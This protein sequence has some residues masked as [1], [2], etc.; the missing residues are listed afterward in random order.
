MAFELIIKPIVIFDI[1]EAVEYYEKKVAGLGNRFYNQFLASLTDIQNKPFTYS[2]IK[3]PVRRCKI[4]HFPYK[5]FYTV[6]EKTVFII[7][8]AHTK[9]SNS[10]VR[11]RLRLL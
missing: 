7:G 11:R 2:Y 5:V 3:D 6:D 8:V 1:E 4:E 9:R 10:F